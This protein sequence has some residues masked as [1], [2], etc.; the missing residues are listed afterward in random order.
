MP[1]RTQLQT[2]SERRRVLAH[3]ALLRGRRIMDDA[4]CAVAE[5]RRTLRE[6]QLPSGRTQ[7]ADVPDQGACSTSRP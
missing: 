3:Q 5:S 7:D 1:V 6:G 4:D 2:L